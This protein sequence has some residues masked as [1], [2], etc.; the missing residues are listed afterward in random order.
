[1]FLC[2]FED[3]FF[4]GGFTGFFFAFLRMILLLGFWG[5]FF[6]WSSGEFFV[7]VLGEF[8]VEKI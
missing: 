8:F 2:V 5:F 7:G 6:V 3:D 1:M 4:C